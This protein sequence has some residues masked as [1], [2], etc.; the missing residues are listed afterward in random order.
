MKIR[1]EGYYEYIEKLDFCSSLARV[2][3]VGR[4]IDYSHKEILERYGSTLLV[5]WYAIDTR[6]FKSELLKELL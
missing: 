1:D 5:R 6:V 4:R 3:D 2:L